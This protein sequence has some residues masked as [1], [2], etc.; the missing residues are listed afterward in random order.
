MYDVYVGIIP[1]VYH[2]LSGCILPSD[3]FCFHVALSNYRLIG[4]CAF[5][6]A[7][8]VRYHRQSY[9]CTIFIWPFLTTYRI[10]IILYFKFLLLP[11]RYRYLC[12]MPTELRN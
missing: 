12:F 8:P 5:V 2:K 3:P 1:V 9:Y 4:G 6:Y 10:I 11:Y 7:V